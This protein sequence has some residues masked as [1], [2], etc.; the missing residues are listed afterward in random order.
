MD[1]EQDPSTW[2]PEEHAGKPSEPSAPAAPGEWVPEGLPA[3]AP[4]RRRTPRPPDPAPAAEVLDAPRAP[5]WTPETEELKARLA[6]LEDQIDAAQA[7]AAALEARR[8]T[9]AE[10]TKREVGAVSDSYDQLQRSVQELRA[11]LERET[12]TQRETIDSLQERLAHFEKELSSGPLGR[13]HRAPRTQAF[14]RFVVFLAVFLAIA[15]A[16]LFAMRRETCHGGGRFGTHWSF[17]KPF[18]HVDAPR[19]CKSQTGATVLLDAVGVK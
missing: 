8:A 3:S 13:V 11:R 19:H 16:P 9:A 14:A 1:R 2:I 10:P 4:R 17:V 7:S 12:G 18:K 15:A 5:Q 6:S